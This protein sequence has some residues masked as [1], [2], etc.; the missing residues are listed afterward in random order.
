[1]ALVRQQRDFGAVKCRP[2]DQ[3]YEAPDAPGVYAWY[4]SPKLT[5]QTEFTK[6]IAALCM[7]TGSTEGRLTIDY[8]ISLFYRALAELRY[9]N[10]SEH[11]LIAEALKNNLTAVQNA[12]E[13]FLVP[14]FTRP[15]YIGMAKHLRTRLYND[16]YKELVSYW[17]PDNPVSRFIGSYTGKENYHIIVDT[18]M[19]RLSLPHSFALEARVR[20]FFPGDL[21]AF[22]IETSEFEPTL[23]TTGLTEDEERVARRTVE[24]LFQ[25]ISLPVCGRI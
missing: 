25:L 20:G 22:F 24:R 9:S 16:H 4:Y 12:F 14:Y 1:M 11:T 3:T 13:S 23:K 15:I 19:S 18:V 21:R 8:G 10:D 17:E 7:S 5:T 2:A 6:Q